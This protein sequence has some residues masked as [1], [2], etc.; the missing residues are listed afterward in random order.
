LAR[1]A[2][3]MEI[4]KERPWGI[5]GTAWRHLSAAAHLVVARYMHPAK[6]PPAAVCS[7]VYRT[8]LGR[9]TTIYP[10]N[11]VN[12]VRCA[13]RAEA[14]YV[15]AYV[16]S[17]PVQTSIARQCSSTTIGP[18]VLTGLPIPS[19]DHTNL[20]HVA[21]TEIGKEAAMDPGKWPSFS[22]RAAEL[23]L[24]ISI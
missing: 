24:R 4:S 23:A 1:S 18:G 6:R 14:D 10:N 9:R 16:N 22:G 8:E 17:E 19:Y 12:F 5:Q 20:D 13:T 3:D 15:A 21:L 11:K 7:P 2:Y